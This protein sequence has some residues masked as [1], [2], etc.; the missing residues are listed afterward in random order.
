M[1]SGLPDLDRLKSQLLTSGLQQKDFPLYQVI[2][3]LIQ[4]LRQ[5]INTLDDALGIS[6]GTGTS[7]NQT[8]TTVAPEK[9]SLPNSRQ[10]TAGQGIQ[11]N[12]TFTRLVINS[13]LPGL[14]EGEQGE[15][16]EIG[17]P[18]NQGPRGLIGPTG[19]MGIGID[20]EDGEIGPIGPTGPRGATGATGA[21]GSG[22][23]LPYWFM[24]EQDE[25]NYPAMVN[26]TN[27]NMIPETSIIDGTILARVAA[28]ETI[29]GQYSFV[30]G[31]MFINA[32]AG[33]LQII[34]NNAAGAA[35]E[36]YWRLLL[37][38]SEVHLQTIND[39]F[40]TGVTFIKV[41]RVGNALAELRI[42]PG[43]TSG[44]ASSI[45]DYVGNFIHL[46]G[47]QFRGR[48]A[49]AISADQTAWNP[50]G[51]GTVFHILVSPSAAWT[52]RGITAQTD[53]YVLAITS[54]L[55]NAL[56]FTHLDGAAASANKIACPNAAAFVLQAFSTVILKY[57]STYG[58]WFVIAKAL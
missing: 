25:M 49:V 51:I 35:D 24:E 13:V 4:A 48:S 15:Q 56:T 54:V 29:T 33:T 9:A 19:P 3:Q 28:N 2:D 21:S 52:M 55:G 57:D 34:T 47:I 45:W 5:T 42:F 20:G 16:G 44:S 37:T 14:I 6:D 53:G 12:D 46:F 32:A 22:S 43:G 17:L 18:G 8:F 30:Q 27:P 23:S 40:T 10:L 39:A 38:G 36:K 58:N 50:S 26:F 41:T 31:S 7:F 11:F 1:A